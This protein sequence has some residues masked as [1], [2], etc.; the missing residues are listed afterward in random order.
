MRGDSIGNVCKKRDSSTFSSIAP[1][2]IDEC[3]NFKAV[4]SVAPALSTSRMD[5]S[6]ASC[7]VHVEEMCDPPCPA[8]RKVCFYWRDNSATITV[9]LVNAR[10]IWPSLDV[11]NL[12]DKDETE[13]EITHFD[14][15]TFAI[16]LGITLLNKN[17]QYPPYTFGLEQ[18]QII[19]IPLDTADVFNELDLA[20]VCKVFH[21]ALF[22]DNQIVA[23]LSSQYIFNTFI[24]G[25]SL[26]DV[27]KT[28]Q[29]TPFENYSPM[30][31]ELVDHFGPCFH[32]ERNDTTIMNSQG[33]LTNFIGTRCASHETENC[34]IEFAYF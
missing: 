29:L 33:D 3:F 6:P 25:R 10:L 7:P 18:R 14:V 15:E 32:P 8:A 1:L 17:R 16:L 5:L 20:Q 26:L 13:I 4:P 28:F 30:Y 11:L 9:N 31:L 27:Q 12:D 2:L 22:L 21:C 19:E 23:R 34:E 24:N